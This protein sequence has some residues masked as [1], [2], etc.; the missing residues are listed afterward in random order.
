MLRGA[1]YGTAGG[2]WAVGGSVFSVTAHATRSVCNGILQMFQGFVQ[3][4]FLMAR[5][6]ARAIAAAINALRL[7][8]AAALCSVGRGL[9]EIW[10]RVMALGRG[11]F[12]VIAQAIRSMFNGIFQVFRGFVQGISGVARRFARVIA[13]AT[14]GLRLKIAASLFSVG[15]V[16]TAIWRRVILAMYTAIQRF[17]TKTLTLSVESGQIRALVLQ[18]SRVL[19][20][21]SAFIDGNP[22]NGER[23]APEV[24]LHKGGISAEATPVQDSDVTSAHSPRSEL[25]ALLE[26]IRRP[27]SRLVA[28]LPLY[29]PLMRHLRA[30][31]ASRRRLAEIIHAEVVDRL[32]FD[33]REVD[34]SWLLRRDTAGRE[35]IAAAVPKGQMDAQVK[36]F[37]GAGG[38]LKAVYSKEAAL[39]FAV[40][41]PD[42]IIVHL[43]PA[44]TAI[45]LVRAC[46]PKVV[47]QLKFPE[48]MTAPEDQAEA[49]ALAVD[50]V[51][52]YYQ[53]VHPEEG[54]QTLPAVL[55]GQLATDSWLA[56]V[57][58]QVLPGPVL[59]FTPSVDCPEGFPSRE[60]AANLGLFLGDKARGE[61]WSDSGPVLNLLP[62]RYL[63]RPFPVVAVAVFIGLLLLAGLGLHLAGPVSGEVQDAD[64]R[65]SEKEDKEK[66][67]RRLRL[68]SNRLTSAAGDVVEAEGRIQ[69]LETQLLVLRGSMA[70]L[71][72]RLETLTRKALPEHVQLLSLVPRDDSFVLSGT[73]A[74]SRDVLEYAASLRHY[75]LFARQD[76]ERYQDETGEYSAN[77]EQELAFADAMVQQVTEERTGGFSFTILATVPAPQTQKNEG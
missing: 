22:N 61:A 37:E 39:A 57:L 18:G 53:T 70:D 42:A 72:I 71:M 69:A 31:N 58:S 41:V 28:D 45:V 64:L 65:S 17:R 48:G 3:G 49:V 40:G 8:I 50:R 20:W 19:V 23:A 29:I 5:R 27:R 74:S 24:E 32:P 11:V 76:V 51:E 46:M 16:L 43:E 62:E 30:P 35:V 25:R 44:Q 59:P 54:G 33:P 13:A 56:D 1:L 34:I 12:S 7:K 68:D 77:L 75:R 21:K 47:Y 52:G 6:V 63:P 66:G 26:A 38:S 36:L 4:I 14:N 9:T 67:E 60:Y 55:T 15:R 73:A 10:R 2:L